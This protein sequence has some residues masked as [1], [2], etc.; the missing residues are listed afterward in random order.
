L[1]KPTAAAAPKP[2]KM[3]L[4]NE[5]VIRADARRLIDKLKKLAKMIPL[6]YYVVAA[7][8]YEAYRNWCHR[9]KLAQGLKSNTRYLNIRQQTQGVDYQLVYLPGWESNEVFK[10]TPGSVSQVRQDAKAI[11]YSGSETADDDT[12]VA[13]EDGQ[14]TG[15]RCRLNPITQDRA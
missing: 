15:W 14:I 10:Q 12:P 6:T 11:Y 8:S 7:Q 9:H 13:N 5:I 2:G 4:Q 3:P 1:T